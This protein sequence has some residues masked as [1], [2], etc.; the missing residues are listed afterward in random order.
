MVPAFGREKLGANEMVT[1]T[2][3]NY[4]CQYA[5][6]WIIKGTIAD[7]SLS[8]LGT[9]NYPDNMRFTRYWNGSNFT[10]AIFVMIIGLIIGL[11]LLQNT[12]RCKDK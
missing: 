6:L 5:A 12:Y 4:F 8:F 1:S 9:P 3:M 10:S 11:V 2:I 7:R